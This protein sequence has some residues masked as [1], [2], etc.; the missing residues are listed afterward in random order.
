MTNHRFVTRAGS[1]SIHD[2]EMELLKDRKLIVLLESIK[3]CTTNETDRIR[4]TQL[5]KLSNDKLADLTSGKE[6]DLGGTFNKFIVEFESIDN[7]N[8]RLV[9]RQKISYRET[10]VIP[11]LQ[12][13]RNYFKKRNLLNL[14]DES[15]TL[16]SDPLFCVSSMVSL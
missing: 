7:P 4:Y 12:R 1:R 9:E 3:Y 14:I 16:T 5:K 6:T 2:N 10:Y 13:I 11:D 15:P 8:D